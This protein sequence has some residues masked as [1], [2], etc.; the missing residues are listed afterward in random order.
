MTLGKLKKIDPREEWKNEAKYFTPWLA[1]NLDEISNVT[2]LELELDGIE[3][4]AGS[5]SV[6][7]LA[8]D[9]GNENYVIIENQLEKTDHDHLGKTITY[10]SML[11][12]NKIIWIATEFREEHKKAFDW[13]ND[14]TNE[15]FSFYA[16]K[17]ELLQIDSSPKAVNFDI[18]SGPN[19]TVRNARKTASGDLSKTQ[20]NQI[21]FWNDFKE[22]IT[23]KDPTIKLRTTSPRNWFDMAIGKSG[24]HVFNTLNQVNNKVECGIYIRNTIADKMLPFL[25][26]RKENIENNFNN[27]EL[28]WNPNPDK[29][30]KKILLSYDYNDLGDN[31]DREKTLEWLSNNALKFIEVF[32]PIVQQFK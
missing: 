20:Q 29:G 25:E 32:S 9:M 10:A 7:I 23:K 31:E 11:N 28:I 22:T 4:K 15:D 2:G 8:K 14:L 24:I 12:A 30:D 5:F 3:V 1:E 6:D 19:Q 27:D 18:V 26:N 13:L 17:L 21:D 16:I